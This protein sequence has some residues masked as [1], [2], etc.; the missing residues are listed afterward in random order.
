[1]LVPRLPW[2]RHPRRSLSV[3]ARVW[4]SHAGAWEPSIIRTVPI[5]PMLPRGNVARVAPCRW[6]RSAWGLP[7]RSVGA[8]NNPYRAD[9]SHAPAWERCPR[10]SLSMVAQCLGAPTQER[11]SHQTSAP[12]RSFPCSR[13]G[14]LPASLPVVGCA[15][16]GGSHAGAWSHQ[17]SY[18]ADRSH[19]PAWERHSRAPCRWLRSAWD[20]RATGRNAPDRPE[21]T[22]RVRL[23]S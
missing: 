2:E 5:V 17:S 1:M 18:R 6:L 19:A 7:R 21:R 11:G 22:F 4:D 13:V 20:S 15:V 12:C 10:R 16:P 23:R 14:T 8:I 9:R 3:V